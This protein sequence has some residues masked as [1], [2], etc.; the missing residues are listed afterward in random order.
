MRSPGDSG[1]QLDAAIAVF[2]VALLVFASPLRALWSGRGAPWYLPLAL[3]LALIVLAWLVQRL[4]GRH[5][6]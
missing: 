1:H 2:V 3:W 4:R 6:L 5:G